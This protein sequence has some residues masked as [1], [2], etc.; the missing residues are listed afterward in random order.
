VKELQKGSN[1]QNELLSTIDGPTNVP[2]KHSDT[3]TERDD[4]EID[5]SVHSQE[6]EL[7][8]SIEN[9]SQFVDQ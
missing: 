5:Q 7:Q 1:L 6:L 4:H 9:T 8:K 2:S 3:V